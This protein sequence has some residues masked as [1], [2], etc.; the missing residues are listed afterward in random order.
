MGTTSTSPGPSGIGPKLA[1]MT[2][3][4]ITPTLFKMFRKIIDDRSVP[5]INL[6]NHISPLLK[7]GKDPS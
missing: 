6:I 7:P 1:K 5:G 3:D 2:V 4:T